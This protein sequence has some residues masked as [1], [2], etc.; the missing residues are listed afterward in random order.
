MLAELRCE[1]L[2]ALQLAEKED[3]FSSRFSR[4][5]LYRPGEDT[6]WAIPFG[7]RLIE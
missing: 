3:I 6:E 1:F 7:S 2:K 5:H 4:H